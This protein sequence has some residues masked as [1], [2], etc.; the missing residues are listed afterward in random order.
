MLSS[1]IKLSLPRSPPA[2]ESTAA[3]VSR[4]EV[5]ERPVCSVRC[6]DRLLCLHDP[7]SSPRKAALMSPRFT[8]ED[9]EHRTLSG[10][11]APHTHSCRSH[12]GSHPTLDPEPEFHTASPE[13]GRNSQ[14]LLSQSW[15]QIP[16]PVQPHLTAL[17]PGQQWARERK[18]LLFVRQHRT[19]GP[20]VPTGTVL[21]VN[22]DKTESGRTVQNGCGGRS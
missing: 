3:T 22:G 11:L 10:L 20:A 15:N 5:T 4:T 19:L 14:Q 13:G 21:R 17:C 8:D 1:L 16:S 9:A 7:H 6:E 2:G 12:D 18:Q